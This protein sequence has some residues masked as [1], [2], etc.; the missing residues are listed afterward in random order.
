MENEVRTFAE[1]CDAP[2]VVLE[3]HNICQCRQQIAYSFPRAFNLSVI[4]PPLEASQIPS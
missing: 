3:M 4:A 2:Q 1:E